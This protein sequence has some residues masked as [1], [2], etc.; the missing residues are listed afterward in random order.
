M[1]PDAAQL[2]P[3]QPAETASAQ[4][5]DADTALTSPG[6]PG[7]VTFVQVRPLECAA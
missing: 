4:I 6:I 1:T 5:S 7:S 3:T 2:Q